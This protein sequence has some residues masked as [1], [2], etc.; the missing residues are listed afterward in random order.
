MSVRN[1]LTQYVCNFMI[2]NVAE[3]EYRENL[4]LLIDQGMYHAETGEGP[5]LARPGV[6]NESP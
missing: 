3:P 1:K 6:T 4:H 5:F 2:N